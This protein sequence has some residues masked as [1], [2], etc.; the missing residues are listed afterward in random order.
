[1]AD[2]MGRRDGGTANPGA[3][4]DGEQLEEDERV[5]W[6]EIAAVVMLAI[7]TVASAWSAYQAARWSGIQGIKFA[8]GNTARLESTRASTEGGQLAQIDV[9][10]FFQWINSFA[11]QDEELAAFYFERFRPEFRP[12]VEAWI[13][14]NPIENPSAPLT[15]FA[16]P[17]YEVADFA[18]AG[19]LAD[20]A[21][22]RL[23]EAKEAN[24]R[25]D[26]YVLAVVLFASVLFFAGIG[27]KFR[28]ISARLALLVLGAL[29]FVGTAAWIA[30]FPIT[31]SI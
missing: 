11:A 23:N 9:T 28:T 17:E 2:Q 4:A 21:T 31:V 12:A 8:E 1:M 16:L 22:D 10:S 6:L 5:R 3:G 7:A 30:T 29:V 13:A 14:T 25:S 19:F 15:P 24:Q 18:E 27:V 26:N 20:Q